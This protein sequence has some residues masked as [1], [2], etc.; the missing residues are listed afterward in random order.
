MIVFVFVLSN[1]WELFLLMIA[2]LSDLCNNW[3]LFLLI[4]VEYFVLSNGL[5]SFLLIIDILLIMSIFLSTDVNDDIEYR[6]KIEQYR[7]SRVEK[8]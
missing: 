4:I 7:T 3:E 1:D 6:I 5:E 2:K 8:K